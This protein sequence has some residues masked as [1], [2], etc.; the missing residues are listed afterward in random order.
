M[1]EAVLVFTQIGGLEEGVGFHKLSFYFTE[2]ASSATAALSKAQKTFITCDAR[3][4]IFFS[5]PRISL[6]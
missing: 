6:L 1:Q 2:I 5:C 4:S 3:P